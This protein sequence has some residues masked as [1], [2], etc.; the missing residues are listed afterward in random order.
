MK[1]LLLLAIAMVVAVPATSMA[2][3]SDSSVGNNADTNQLDNF[4]VAGNLGTSQY[5]D[6][7]ASNR[8]KYRDDLTHDN[9]V[10]QNLRFGWR[11]DG[12]VGPEIGYA[13]FGK[14]KRDYSEPYR[15]YSI[16]PKALTV[17]ANGKYD[18][19]DNWFVTAHAGW[20]R[21][22]TTVACTTSLIPCEPDHVFGL[23]GGPS[24][25]NTSYR[26]GWYAGMG[27]GYDVTSNVSVGLNYDD[28]NIKYNSTDN[29]NGFTDIK[30]KRNIAAFSTSLEY[31][32]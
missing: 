8:P 31:R 30:A 15:V 1:K 16:Q 26:N 25:S 7:T 10:F 3:Q 29:P 20:L 24:V 4:F 28:Y 23:P 13:Y 9:G 32:F 18:F 2:S 17:G 22:H 19:H 5:R 14:G 11:W 6:A 12:I 21:S 27:V